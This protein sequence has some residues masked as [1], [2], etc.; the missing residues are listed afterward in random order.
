VTEGSNEEGST[1]DTAMR[2]VVGDLLGY[3]KEP[4]VRFAKLSQ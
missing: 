4:G 1:D 2:R 3:K